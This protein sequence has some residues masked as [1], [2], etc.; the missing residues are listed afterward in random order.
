MPTNTLTARANTGFGTDTIAGVN[1]AQGFVGAGMMT[2]ATGADI[3]AAN[4]FPVNQAGV[5]ATGTLGALNANVALSLNGA[6]GFA[7]DL[8]GT[9]TATVTFQGTIDGTNWF[10]LAVVPAGSSVNVASVTTATAAGAW[11]GNANGMQQ[12]RAIATSYTSGTVT[13]VLRAMQA[14]G[15][16]LNMPAGATTQTIGALPAGTNLAADVGIQYRG[17]ATGAASVTAVTSPLVPAGQ[18]I[19]GSAGR[20]VAYDLHNQATT[21]RFVK[22]FNATTVT[23]GTTSALFEVA[24]DPGQTKTIDIPGGIGFAT[25]IMIAV[26]SG[27]GLTDNTTTGVALGDVTGFVAFA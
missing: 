22:F 14:A 20:V 26:T 10:T 19:K 5:S 3:T 13:V 21:R 16:V 4:P 11:V 1:T 6:T 17:S 24:L 23:M 7:V 12:V 18:S 27:R 15:V 8:R 2:D 25:G 9:F